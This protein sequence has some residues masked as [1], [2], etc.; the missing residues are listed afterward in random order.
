MRRQVIQIANVVTIQ[1]KTKPFVKVRRWRRCRS[2]RCRDAPNAVLRQN[3]FNLGTCAPSS[4][5][6]T[7]D[8]RAWNGTYLQNV[9]RHAS[10]VGASARAASTSAK[11]VA[12]TR[13]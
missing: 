13:R 10:A 8:A 9:K 2:G 1:G 11:R 3:V 12:R 6:T 4:S 7:R 5:V